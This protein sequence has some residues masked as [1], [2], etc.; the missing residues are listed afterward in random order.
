MIG[1]HTA[2]N[3][4]SL[5]EQFMLDYPGVTMLLDVEGKILRAN[6]QARLIE[7]AV[8]QG[9]ADEVAS[10]AK[11]AVREGRVVAKTIEV[12]FND[13]KQVIE[14]A[15]MPTSAPGKV[16]AIGRNVTLERNLR[17]ALVE[18]RQRYK[19][20]VEI[21]S[22]FSWEVGIDKKFAFV[23]PRGALG[24]PATELVGHDPREF[25]L[26]QNQEENLIPFFAN[27][28]IEDAEIWTIR[29][30]G[31]AACMSI[32][33]SP[34]WGANGEWRGARGVCRD[35][36]EIRE[37]D[38]ALAKAGNRERL[39]THIVRTV[40]DEVDPANMLKA[41]TA[42]TAGSLGAAGCQVF[43]YENSQFIQASKFGNTGDAALVDR[44]LA[45]LE[46][47]V[48]SFE[49]ARDGWEVLAATSRYHG[50]INGA[51]FL[52]RMLDSPPWTD[53][54]RILIG[55]VANQIGIANEQIGNHER[56]LRLS[57]TDGLTGLF[58]R[59]AFFEEVERRF[60]RLERENKPAALIY[61]DLDNFKLVNDVHGHQ[62]GDEALVALRDILINNTR[63][64]DLV[65][66]LGG[67]EF[68]V[69]LE[70]GDDVVSIKRAEILLGAGHT[71]D[72]F[73]GTREKP[74]GISIGIAVYD[75]NRPETLEHL[76]ARADEAMYLVKR[77]GKGNYKLAPI[78]GLPGYGG[79]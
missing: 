5:P 71:L 45:N 30:D 53:D 10:L 67:D 15:F 60:N 58:N 66:R 78:A 62:R 6:P 49:M 37:R 50:E 22:D 75:P 34:L 63:P 64:V 57:R 28:P 55:D 21:S 41:A 52:W 16:L 1:D 43:R 54:D 33:A 68:G 72:N 77:D 11:E 23:S 25:M 46:G 56:I 31:Q 20:L 48:E 59:R 27:S 36:T 8:A 61:I 18:S 51:L 38:A 4:L 13:G 39:L 44:M 3:V 26:E 70:G 40:R 65:A 29:V 19:D 24:R 7:R 35:V 12:P 79:S 14:L 47:G 76:I 73:S 74:L 2:L 69:W 17:A 32:S 9:G 42:A